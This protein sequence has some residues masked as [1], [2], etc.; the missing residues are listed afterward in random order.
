MAEVIENLSNFPSRELTIKF[1]Y[2][3]HAIKFTWI[4]MNTKYNK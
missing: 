1:K 4:N 2:N 3:I